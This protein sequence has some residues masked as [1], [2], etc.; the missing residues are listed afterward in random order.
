MQGDETGGQRSVAIPKYRNVG[1]RRRGWQ[2]CGRCTTEELLSSPRQMPATFV[3]NSKTREQIDLDVARSFTQFNLGETKLATCREQLRMLL[4]VIF[5]YHQ[6]LHYYQGFNDLCSV[7]LLTLGLED[8]I[9]MISW[10]VR[11]RLR[12]LLD[13]GDFELP[14][15][16]VDL[17]FGIL[18]MADPP[19]YEKL[20]SLDIPRYFCISW[21]ITWFAHDLER[22]ST[23]QVCFDFFLAN[24]PVAVVYAAA[25]LPMLHRAQLLAWKDIGDPSI[26]QFLKTLPRKMSPSL[27]IR[28]A[29]L[30]MHT[31]PPPSLL[32]LPCSRRLSG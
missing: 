18:Q 9:M 17:V 20:S 12:D 1:E 13:R 11:H 22:L 2:A 15:A 7:V 4:Y 26:H 16:L 31:H 27:L 14:L 24:E 28:Q 5:F 6:D 29:A 3:I 19:L 8:A 21:I 23:A 30:L 10:L 32:N 25:A